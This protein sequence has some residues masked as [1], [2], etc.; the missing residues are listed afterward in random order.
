MADLRTAR[1]AKRI[2]R[3][4]MKWGSILFACGAGVILLGFAAARYASYSYT[5]W[6]RLAVLGGV[7]VLLYLGFLPTLVGA[8]L[9]ITGRVSE[10]KLNS[11]IKSR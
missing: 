11:Q 9:W 1:Q 5:S 7:A 3:W 2:G 8:V 6:Q 4:L 10:K